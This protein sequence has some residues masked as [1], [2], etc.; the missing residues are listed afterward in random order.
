MWM[1]LAR[2][3]P[4]TKRLWAFLNHNARFG[5]RFLP[6]G[7]LPRS[8]AAKD[9]MPDGCR[10]I[11]LGMESSEEQFIRCRP[12]RSN[13]P[14]CCKMPLLRTSVAVRAV[15]RG[16]AV[17]L[18]NFVSVLF[19][20]SAQMSVDLPLSDLTSETRSHVAPTAIGYSRCQGAYNKE[21]GLT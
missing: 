18:D 17:V 12:F 4:Q 10:I 5:G 2:L 14:T 21:I 3:P 9:G 6:P 19:R 16:E 1:W 15:H 11:L 8:F 13:W 20:S 7:R